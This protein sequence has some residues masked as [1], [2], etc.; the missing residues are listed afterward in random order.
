M[1]GSIR[2]YF[3]LNDARATAKLVPEDA[4]A[5]LHDKLALGRQ[6]SEA[7]DALWSNGHVAEG[8]R[9]ASDAF[10]ATL[11]AIDS[12]EG[13]LAPAPASQAA[14]EAM[15]EAPTVLA[16]DPEEPKAEA[17][18]EA[19][20]EA[21]ADAD[22]EETEAEEAEAEEAEA[23]APKAEAAEAEGEPETGGEA[24][25]DEAP[26]DEAPSPPVAE[27]AVALRADVRPDEPSWAAVLRRR[28]LSDGKTREVLEAE[29]SLRAKVLPALDK[30][31]G[32]ADGELFQS[33]I[34][35]RRHVDR[36]LSPAS[37]TVGQLAWTRAS[38]LGFTAFFVVAA[39]F[40]VYWLLKPA[41]GVVATASAQYNNDF[42]PA[43]AVDGDV[44]TE[45]LLPDRQPG[46]LDLRITP[47]QHIETDRKSVV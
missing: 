35:A 24:P 45:W 10:E 14:R 44:A 6:R 15:G 46:Q 7:A 34:T 26:S 31:V 47:P 13:A 21:G 30:D 12:F 4:R 28:G 5:S 1:I 43:K 8:L 38:R 23:E 19:G 22:A 42:P 29:R 36:V 17:D 25:S 32:A 11:A 27:T 39:V 41:T 18:A 40:G 9:L 33:L 37:M 3:F 16:I 2:E 20:A